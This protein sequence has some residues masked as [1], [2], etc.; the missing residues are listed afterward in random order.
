MKNKLKKIFS[1]VF[2]P[3]LL[4]CFGIA[5]F[6]TN[7]WS[8]VMLGFGTYFEIHWITAVAAAYLTFLWLPISPEKIVTFAIAIGLLRLIFPHDTATL[9]VLKR[10]AEK[11]REAL[12]RG[13]KRKSGKD[14]EEKRSENHENESGS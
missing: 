1:F 2:N 10:G 12:R 4:L 11:A 9:A 13:R 14:S 8:Y 3:R 7:G 5:W 6:I